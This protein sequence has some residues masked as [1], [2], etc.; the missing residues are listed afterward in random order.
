MSRLKTSLFALALATSGLTACSQG[1]SKVDTSTVEPT[2]YASQLTLTPVASDLEVPWAIAF[3]PSG[4]MLVTERE[5]RLTLIR[6]GENITVSGTPDALV[7][8]QGGY[9][10]LLLAED[11][12][13]S[14]TLY[15]SFSNG[16]MESNSTSIIKG[17]LS[18]D[19]TAFENGEIIYEAT[20]RN[21]A[22]HFGGRMQFM[23]DGTLL[24]SLGD[25]FRYMDEAQNTNNTHGKIIRINTDGSIPED[26]P[27]TDGD[28]PEV[29]SYGHRNVQGLFVDPE[30]GTVYAH[31][32]GPKGGDEFNIIEAGNNY[33]WPIITYGINYDGSIITEET[34]REGMEQPVEKWVPSIA[35]SG[36]V[37][38]TGDA[39]E[40]WQGDYFVGGM[41]GPAGQKLVRLDMEN[42]K[43]VGKEDLLAGL[44]IPFR[45]VAQ[46]PDGKLYLAGADFGDGQIYRLDV[47]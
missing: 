31:E 14:R 8:R 10:G 7:E 19:G 20:K 44:N 33:G 38:Y 39:Y 47:N 24:L 12:E 23:Q 28:A 45:D 26:N 34:A 17:T 1:S 30:T 36:L 18:A 2:P 6:D 25:G 37:K 32:H 46:G 27:F 22:F 4:E 42:G 3:L 21:T 40:G 11:F 9:L 15:M 43:Y 41:N 5:G 35:P 16:P 29:Y 13:T